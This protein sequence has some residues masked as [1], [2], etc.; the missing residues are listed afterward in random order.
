MERPEKRMLTHATHIV[1]NH[2]IH[3]LEVK[4]LAKL[5]G[6]S[7]SQFHAYF[8]C[9]D[10]LLTEVFNEGWSVIQRCIGKRLCRPTP[11]ILDLVESVLNGVLDAFQED[12]EAVSATIMLGFETIGQPV[13]E[14]LRITP[15]FTQFKFMAEQLIDELAK[16]V[17]RGEAKAVIQLLLGAVVRHL[18]LM[19]PM[20]EKQRE[21]YGPPLEREQ[22]ISVMRR[23]ME[24][25][26]A[27]TASAR[28]KRPQVQEAPEGDPA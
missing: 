19:T 14:R 8:T 12:V 9:R 20:Y 2:G 28:A 5:A 16:D 1:A 11:T 4:R 13:R 21:K 23:M 18:M 24:G 6:S 3:Q 26:L 10:Q 7:T 25:L 17:P 15:G 27:E 22:F